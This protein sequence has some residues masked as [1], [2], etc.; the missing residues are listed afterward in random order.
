MTIRSLVPSFGKK[1]VP[2]RYNDSPFRL[3]HEDM[4]RLFDD[5]FRGF[6]LEPFDRH[7][8]SFNPDVEVSE[9]DKEIKVSAELPGMDEKDIDVSLTDNELTI[10][11]EKKEEKER[12]GKDYFMKERSY[13]SFKRSIPLY[14]EIETE[15]VNAHFNKG[16]LTITM[17]K[18]AKA[19]EELKKIKIKVE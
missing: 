19:I 14:S 9:N 3:L 11:G 17:P 18:S 5:F 16:V 1:R 10:S 7:L 15:K 12:N 6:D 13:G 8:N 4:N 2:V